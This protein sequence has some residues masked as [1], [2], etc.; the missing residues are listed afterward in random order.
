L[1]ADKNPMPL[2]DDYPGIY[3]LKLDIMLGQPKN[4]KTNPTDRQFL[5]KM[6]NRCPVDVV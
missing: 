6:I 2:L 5:W 4:I 3:A 1:N